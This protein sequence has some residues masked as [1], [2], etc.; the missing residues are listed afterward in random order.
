[1]KHHHYARFFAMTFL[2]FLAM[3]AFTYSMVFRW[4]DVH[5]SLSRGYMAAL[6]TAP[7]VSL[8]MALMGG[9]YPRK[10]LNVAIMVAGVVAMVGFWAAIRTEAGVGDVQFLKSMIPH[11]SGAILM[12]DRAALTDPEILELCRSIVESQQRE[13]EQMNRILARLDP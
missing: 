12:C 9:M 13:I 4:D 6:M 5:P 8:E 1:M 7:M 11:H 10:K 3:Y 2:S